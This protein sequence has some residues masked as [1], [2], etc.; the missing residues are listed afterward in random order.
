MSDLSFGKIIIDKTISEALLI[1]K[2]N[3]TGDIFIVD[4]TDSQIRLPADTTIGTTVNPSSSTGG[5][6]NILGDTVTDGM[7]IHT[8]TG[9]SPPSFTNRSSGSKIVLFPS[10][11]G[12]EVDYA[13][14]IDTSVFWFSVPL[15]SRNYKWYAGE[16]EI[17]QLSG[18]GNLSITGTVDGRDISV[19]GGNLDNLYTT[20]GLSAL[21]SGEVNQLENIGATTISSTQWGYLGGM[22][23][24]LSVDSSV[25]FHTVLIDSTATTALLVRK[26]S[27][28]GDVFIVDTTNSIVAVSGTVIIDNTS[29]EAL[30]VR[31]AGDTGDIFSVDTTNN[32]SAVFRDTNYYA[33]YD[34]TDANLVFDSTDYLSFNRAF[35]KYLFKIGGSTYFVVGSAAIECETRVQIDETSTEALLVRK[36]GDGGDVFTVDTTNSHISIGGSMSL[37]SEFSMI[38][39]DNL[40]RTR[41]VSVGSNNY[42]QSSLN[43]TS[44]SYVPLRFTSNGGV[45]TFLE[46]LDTGI[47]VTG[48]ITVSGTVD[49]IDIAT[50]DGKL[51]TLYT[52]IGLSALTSGEV[53]Q[54]ENIGATTISATQWG[55]LGATDQSLATTDAVQFNSA[56]IDSTGTEAFLVRKDGDGG[57]VFT[58]DTTNAVTTSNASFTVNKTSTTALLIRTDGAAST[59]FQVNTSTPIIDINASTIIDHT[60]T[61]AL[62]VRKNGDGGDVFTVDTTNILSR[63][64]GTHYIDVTNAGALIVR[65]AD[66]TNVFLV[67][68]SSP[69]IDINASTII[70]HT[71]NEALLVRK[72][73]DG[74]D[75]FS[76]DTTDSKVLCKVVQSNSGNVSVTTGGTVLTSFRSKSGFITIGWGN[77][78][79]LAFFNWQEGLNSNV[80]GSIFTSS[81]LNDVTL[82]LVYNDPNMEI[83]ATSNTT[84]TVYWSV[85][86]TGQ[87]PA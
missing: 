81:S 80:I 87:F 2:K 20:I 73:G 68:T 21:T 39:V 31:K 65:K 83:V 6:L 50:Q 16:T 19:D 44:D 61:E 43:A 51:E 71:S 78:T 10:I 35:N 18:G 60:S 1:R 11:S 53:N 12:S 79:R 17:M 37:I 36:S 23:Q 49:G 75:V 28:G 3:D 55:Y 59:I 84:L 67:N 76:V 85:I 69:Q 9:I 64:N 15:N 8:N 57:D 46:I 77:G 48:N 5:S 54:L 34:G 47:D 42:I 86:Y 25:A 13:M 24:G 82:S 56:I 62:L 4:T 74:G 70:D 52:T 45:R 7:F 38:A 22:D 40:S 41:F 66:F 58:V 72:D 29:T 26:D 33:Q 63:T 27:G 30:L 32:K 14:G